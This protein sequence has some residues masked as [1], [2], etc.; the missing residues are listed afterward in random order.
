MWHGWARLDGVGLGL[1]KTRLLNGASS[2]FGGGW[3]A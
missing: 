1:K 2:G 3:R